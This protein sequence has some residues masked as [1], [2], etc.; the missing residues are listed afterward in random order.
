MENAGPGTLAI[1]MTTSDP[2]LA[3][4]LWQHGREVLQRFPPKT[5]ALV[6]RMLRKDGP[7]ARAGLKEWDA[8]AAADGKPTR[9]SAE[10]L[11][12]VRSKRPGETLKLTVIRPDGAGVRDVEVRLGELEVGWP[13]AKDAQ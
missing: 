13:E 11:R 1:D 5:E 8:V 2:D 6:L 9:L 12:I 10:L 4:K 3:E 7:V